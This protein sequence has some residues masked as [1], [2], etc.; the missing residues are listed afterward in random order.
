MSHSFVNDS[1]HAV[2][3]ACVEIQCTGANAR[4]LVLSVNVHK[5]VL[6]FQLAYTYTFMYIAAL[7]A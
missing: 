2:Y 3:I 6:E 4:S 7:K 5:E 1:L